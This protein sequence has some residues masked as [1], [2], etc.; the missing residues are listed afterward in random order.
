MKNTHLIKPNISFRREEYE[1]WVKTASQEEREAY[2]NSLPDFDFEQLVEDNQEEEEAET[3]RSGLAASRQL[4]V[5]LKRAAYKT[6]ALGRSEV[7]RGWMMGNQR[8][9][10]VRSG[11]EVVAIT[12]TE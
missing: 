11:G 7:G 1:R 12:E 8:C 5:E 2:W 3:S 10:A 6:A 4:S 9:R